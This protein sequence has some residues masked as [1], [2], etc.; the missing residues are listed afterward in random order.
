MHATLLEVVGQPLYNRNW[1]RQRVLEHLDPSRLVGAVYLAFGTHY[2]GH[3]I[4][5]VETPELGLFSTTYVVPEARGRGIARKLIA[6]G[7][8]WMRNRALNRACTYTASDNRP[9]QELFRSLGYHM[10][11]AEAM[12]VQLE[13]RLEGKNSQSD[14]PSGDTT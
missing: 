5:R 4:V 3:T 1:L 8:R 13:R 6:R 10:S 2:L 7:G 9:L 14:E 12:F 11:P